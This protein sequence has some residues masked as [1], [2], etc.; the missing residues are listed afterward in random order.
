MNA[1]ELKTLT[2]AYNQKTILRDIGFTIEKGEFCGIIGPNGA[3]KSTLLRVIAGILK[4]KSGNVSVMGRDVQ[5]IRKKEF[6]RLVGFVPQETHFYLNYTVE[7]IITMGRYPYLEP[8][9]ML[10]K[11]DISAIEWAIEQTQTRD[12]CKRPINALSA[13]E[14]QMVVIARALA[15]NP[16]LLLLDEPTSHLDIQHQSAIMELLKKLNNQGITIIIVNHDLNLASQFCK[17]LILLHQGRIYKMGKPEEIINQKTIAEVYKI[18]TDIIQHPE[19]NIPQ[20]LLK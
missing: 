10:N 15:Q 6:A 8:F 17:R 14:K 1:V 5:T 3:G 2:F 7:D 19:K 12:L 18:D 16:E 11:Q 4:P 9:Q 20:V 13:G